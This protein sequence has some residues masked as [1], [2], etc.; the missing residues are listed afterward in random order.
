MV[1]FLIVLVSLFLL[2]KSAGTFV[3]QASALAKKLKIGDF[4]IGFTVVAFGTSLPEL[5]STIFSAAS[6]HN[7][8]VVSNIIGSNMTNSCLIFGVIAL[9]NNYRI[10]KRDVDINIPLNMTALVSFWALSTYMGFSL[11]W[12]S[13][14]SL[15][16]IFFILLILSKEY[17]HFETVERKYA[18]FHPIVFVVSLLLLIF[19]GKFCIDQ[20]IYMSSQLNISETILGYFLLAIG[21]SLPELVTTWMAVKKHD[22]ELGVGNILGSNLFNLMFILGISTFIRPLQLIGFRTDLV[23]LSGAT[24]AV[25]VF[26]VLG[27][28][29]S[30]SKKEGAGMLLIYALFVL[31]Q[32]SRL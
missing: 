11:N 14:I 31:F 10:R 13:G 23:F 16:L 22:G 5:I 20:I 9:F 8:L 1:S 19:S 24:L 2:V 6:G 18:V 30:F 7:Q 3:D 15:I 32:I 12:A 28:R 17:N 26:A 4:L 25:Y 29:Y 21:T 27:R